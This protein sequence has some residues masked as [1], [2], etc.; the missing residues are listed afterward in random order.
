MFLEV[1]FGSERGKVISQPHTFK[2]P[3]KEEHS[4]FVT[5]TT[6]AST[7]VRIMAQHHYASFADDKTASDNAANTASVSGYATTRRVRPSPGRM[8]PDCP[9]KLYCCC[10]S[11][12][13]SSRDDRRG[14]EYKDRCTA[15]TDKMV[16]TNLVVHQ[17]RLC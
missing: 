3:Q 1:P 6:P 2:Q 17:G 8:R 9:W 14:E 10:S 11:Q 5:T 16:S 4:I 7:F 12:G 15:E 13:K